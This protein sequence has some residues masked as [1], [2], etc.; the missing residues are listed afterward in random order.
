MGTHYPFRFST[1]SCRLVQDREKERD[2]ITLEHLDE[3]VFLSRDRRIL[4]VTGD[5][6]DRQVYAQA[7]G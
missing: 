4:T 5:V 3:R 1:E 7:F 2:N 6:V